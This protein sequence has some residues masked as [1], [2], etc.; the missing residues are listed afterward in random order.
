MKQVRKLA[1][2]IYLEG[3]FDMRTG[4]DNYAYPI[5]FP[6]IFTA[7]GKGIKSGN[8][9]SCTGTNTPEYIAKYYS[10]NVKPVST[11]YEIEL[12][13]LSEQEKYEL[14]GLWDAIATMAEAYSVVK[15]GN[16]GTSEGC[17]IS[18]MQCAKS[19]FKTIEPM[20]KRANELLNKFPLI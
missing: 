8:W 20:A 4:K 16:K 7:M 15:F 18:D 2:K 12:P 9:Q 6:T 5:D 3:S 17:D 10:E 11:N 19:I 1:G 13:F 14:F